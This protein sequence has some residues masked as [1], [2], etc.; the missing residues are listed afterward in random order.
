[1]VE[2]QA[3][4]STAVADA[5]KFNPRQRAMAHPAKRGMGHCFSP[6]VTSGNRQQQRSALGYCFVRVPVPWSCPQ[7]PLSAQL[8]TVKVVPSGENVPVTATLLPE[9]P[10]SV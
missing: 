10:E 8:V 6:S 1:M 4:A 9:P 2:S 7:G 3:V 5:A